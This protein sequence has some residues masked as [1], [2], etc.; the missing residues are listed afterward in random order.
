MAKKHSAPSRPL[1]TYMI[2]ALREAARRE[3]EFL[4][5][6]GIS[7]SQVCK[8]LVTRG[9]MSFG[10]YSVDGKNLMGFHLTK[11]GKDIIPS[12]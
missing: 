5:P 11:K 8:G 3:A 7:R 6:I 2:N 12:L 10:Q 4:P 1:T 9:F